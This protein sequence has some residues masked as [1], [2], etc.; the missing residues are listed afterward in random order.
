MY[1]VFAEKGIRFAV[2]GLTLRAMLP[3]GPDEI[4]GAE[5]ATLPLPAPSRVA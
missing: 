5:V 4:A 3:P 2:G 1:Q